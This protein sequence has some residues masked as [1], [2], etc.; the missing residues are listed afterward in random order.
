[1]SSPNFSSALSI[2]S[3]GEAFWSSLANFSKS[4]ASTFSPTSAN[5]PKSKDHTAQESFS[6]NIIET[7]KC[8]DK[9]SKFHVPGATMVAAEG[10]I[11]SFLLG[12]AFNGFTAERLRE[13]KTVDKSWGLSNGWKAPNWDTANTKKNKQINN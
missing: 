7:N 1:M 2:I 11:E 5:S 12:S 4:S 10:T 8:K 13:F 9:Y 6:I 3:K